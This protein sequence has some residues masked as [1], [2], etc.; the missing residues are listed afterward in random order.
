MAERDT[1]LGLLMGL[2]NSGGREPDWI[3]ALMGKAS[4][5]KARK[6][7]PGAFE[8]V[9]ELDEEHRGELRGAVPLALSLRFLATALGRLR[10]G[11]E[12]VPALP[13]PRPPE[14]GG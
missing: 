2:P 4:P 10:A 1:P 8:R 13:V 6:A 9:K 3:R 5:S 14:A 11:T 12:L 7:E